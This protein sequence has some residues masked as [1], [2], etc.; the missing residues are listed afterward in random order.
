M[1]GS[2]PMRT[3]V[4]RPVAVEL[5]VHALTLAQH[6]EQRPVERFGRE[7]VLGAVGVGDDDRPRRT[8]GRRCGRRPASLRLL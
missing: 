8:A 5:E 3:R 2:E 1:S 6:P 4:A 7:H